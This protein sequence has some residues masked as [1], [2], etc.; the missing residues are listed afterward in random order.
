MRLPI[1][2]LPIFLYSTNAIK[3]VSLQ[4]HGKIATLFACLHVWLDS[5]HQA[6]V[7]SGLHCCYVVEEAFHVRIATLMNDIDRSKCLHHLESQKL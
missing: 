6:Y 7:L 5:T 1:V 2:N 3:F 4:R